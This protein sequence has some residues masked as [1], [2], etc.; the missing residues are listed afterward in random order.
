MKQSTR[1]YAKR[2]VS[3]L[4]NKLL[5]VVYAA[6]ADGREPKPTTPT[7]VLDATGKLYGIS[8]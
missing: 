4:K 8:V 7:Y 1:K 5:P 3:W 2:Q 6:N